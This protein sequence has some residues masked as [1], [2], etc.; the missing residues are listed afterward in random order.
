MPIS[1]SNTRFMPHF[2]S[3]FIFI[4]ETISALRSGLSWARVTDSLFPVHTQGSVAGRRI[5]RHTTETIRGQRLSSFFTRNNPRRS[6]IEDGDTLRRLPEQTRVVFGACRK[7]KIKL[8]HTAQSLVYTWFRGGT[9]RADTTH[10]HVHR[11]RKRACGQHTRRS[12]HPSLTY[13]RMSHQTT[14]QQHVCANVVFAFD[15]AA[16]TQKRESK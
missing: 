16:G 7:E 10:V 5:K 6:V 15:H 1:C 3:L 2:S 9:Y 11:E 4:S 14:R 12:T 13:V 8:K